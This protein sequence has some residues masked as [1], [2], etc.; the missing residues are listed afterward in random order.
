MSDTLPALN[1]TVAGHVRAASGATP[2]SA[3]DYKFWFGLSRSVMEQ[4]ADKWEA[5]TETY[6]GVRQ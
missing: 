2:E 3:T 4:I 5:T 6:A 1:T